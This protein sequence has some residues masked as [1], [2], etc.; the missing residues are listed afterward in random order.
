M[1]VKLLKADWPLE[2]VRDALAA[3]ELRTD[4]RGEKLSLEQFAA[5]TKLLAAS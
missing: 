5:L 2:R 3:L 1:L 4:V